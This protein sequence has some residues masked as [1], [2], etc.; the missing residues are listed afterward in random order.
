MTEEGSPYAVLGLGPS[1]TAEQVRAAYRAKAKQV[2][3]DRPGGDAESFVAVR[4]AY[5]VLR[6]PVR[7][8][9]LDR[10]RTRP[11]V[12]SPPPAARPTPGP[13][14]SGVAATTDDLDARWEEVVGAFGTPSHEP[15]HEP[16]RRPR[17]RG[18][19]W[20]RG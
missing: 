7:R 19:A 16:S 11:T 18:W 15:S 8:A 12:P 9:E 17:R 20:W 14:L 4:R 1:A 10:A 3:P 2:H 6:D 13:D 5:D